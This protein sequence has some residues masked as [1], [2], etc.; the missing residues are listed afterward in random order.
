MSCEKCTNIVFRPWNKLTDDEARRVKR[1]GVFAQAEKDKDGNLLFVYIHHKTMGELQRSNEHCHMCR[2]LFI[3]FQHITGTGSAGKERKNV[4]DQYPRPLVYL[5]TTVNEKYLNAGTLN[6]MSILS[7]HC[8]NLEIRSG[9]RL[10]QG[11]RSLLY[12]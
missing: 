9:A 10:K 3:A 1:P 6:R 2:K 8:G 12:R 5:L 7:A 11:T 4:V